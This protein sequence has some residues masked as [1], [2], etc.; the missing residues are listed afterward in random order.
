MIDRLS[1]LVGRALTFR[2]EDLK[3]DEGQTTVEY[4]VVLVLVIALA[5]AAFTALSQGV[6]DFMGTIKDKLDAAVLP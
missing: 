1:M 2:L 6:S 5:I 4:A 3:S